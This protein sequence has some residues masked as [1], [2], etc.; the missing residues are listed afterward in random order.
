MGNSEVKKHDGEELLAVIKIDEDA[1]SWEEVDSEFIENVSSA[2]NLQKDIAKVLVANEKVIN[3]DKE[4]FDVSKGLLETIKD[5]VIEY[6]DNRNLY[7]D[8]IG[9]E[10]DKEDDEAVTTYLTVKQNFVSTSEK[11]ANIALIALT[12]VMTRLNAKGIE[13]TEEIKELNDFANNEVTENGSN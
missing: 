10:I 6:K 9:T 12:D 7:F 11:F 2:I 1:M 3:E 5:V 8:R 13:L 4:L